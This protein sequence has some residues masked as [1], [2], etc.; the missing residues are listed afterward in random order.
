MTPNK[1]KIKGTTW[2]RSLVKIL[3]ERIKKGTF[4]RVPGSGA[5]GTQLD[6]PSL[7]SDIK[8]RVVGL[9][10]PIKIE[11]K[12]GYGGAKQLTVKKEWLDKVAEEANRTYSIPFLICRFSGSR[13]GV[14]DFVVMDIDIFIDLMNLIS[15]LTE[16][17]T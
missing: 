16:N 14:E 8:G 3:N 13:S 5:M 12:V 17:E 2:E 4:K 15:E 7:Y 9:G 1:Q 11:A 6:E 10:K